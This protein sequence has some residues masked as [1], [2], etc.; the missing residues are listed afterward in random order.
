MDRPIDNSTR[1]RHTRQQWLRWALAILLIAVAVWAFRRWLQPA[2]SGNAL[3]IAAVETGDIKSTITATGL[4]VA[5]FEEQL[6]APVSTTIRQLLVPVGKE[7]QPGELILSLDREYVQ[8]QVDSRADQ[9]ALKR[10]N[11]DLLKLSYDRD[12]KELD[13]DSRIKTLQLSTAQ[14]QLADARRLLAVGGA[15]AEDVER[16][17]LQVEITTLERDKLRNELAYR[18]S[19][20]DGRRRNLELEVGMEQKEL[21][22][23]SRKLRETEVRA[24]RAG[25]VTWLNEKIGQQVPEGAP[26]V[27]IADLG[28]FR[29]EA[30]CSDRYADNIKTGQPVQVK[31]PKLTIGGTV[32]SIL[33]EV[34]NNTLR[35][36]VTLNEPNHPALRPNLKAETE[37]IIGEKPQVLRVKNGP[38]FRG[39]TR[40]DVFVVRGT[41]A[42]ATN[43]GLGI[44]SSDFI[45]I[46]DGLQPGDRVII[47]DTKEFEGRPSIKIQ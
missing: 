30:S 13:Y 40:Q 16:A 11:V 4:I 38:A 35:F 19:S 5:T 3:R 27:R 22:Q 47:S 23:L 31:L 24:P 28:H 15:T 6:N 12:I 1:R 45:E 21:A 41:E 20:L 26:L 39:G 7:V 37:V 25:V 17:E 10:N 42:I 14:A 33:P 29:M 8:L 46:T 18:R 9:L 36:I 34:E 2:T 43:I 32:T 44:R